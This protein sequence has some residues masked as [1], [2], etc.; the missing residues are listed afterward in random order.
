M[1]EDKS[2]TGTLVQV[3]GV[4]RFSIGVRRTSTC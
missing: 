4:E 3:E 1:N 2:N